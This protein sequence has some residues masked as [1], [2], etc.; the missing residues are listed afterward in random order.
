MARYSQL[1]IA[2]FDKE[3]LAVADQEFNIQFVRH[4]R[5]M[6]VEKITSI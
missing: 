2:I 1:I 5:G 3:W 6:L 4:Y